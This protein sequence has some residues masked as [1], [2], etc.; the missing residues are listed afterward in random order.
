[1]P[2]YVKTCAPRRDARA[3]WSLG[4]I[5]SSGKR[6]EGGE[7]KEEEGKEEGGVGGGGG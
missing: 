3:F 7:G 6:R 5:R 2:L 1:M 4:A